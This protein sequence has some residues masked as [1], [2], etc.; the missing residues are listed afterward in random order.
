VSCWARLTDSRRCLE[1][2]EA[3]YSIE[4]IF[5]YSNYLPEI[6]KEV[7][8]FVMHN[9]GKLLNRVVLVEVK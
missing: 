5:F 6:D 2:N 8:T 7:L 3:A 4:M 9:S 1:G